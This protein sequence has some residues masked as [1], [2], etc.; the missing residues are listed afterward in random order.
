MRRPCVF[1]PVYACSEGSLAE[2]LRFFATHE[3]PYAGHCQEGRD[4][5]G[6]VAALLECF[7]GA[8]Y[9]EVRK[10][11][12]ST[13]FSYY[14]IEPRDADYDQ[15]ANNNIAATLRKLIGLEDLNNAD[16][17]GAAEDFFREI[18]LSG[19]ELAALRANLAKSCFEGKSKYA[20][21]ENWAYCGVGTDKGADIFIVGPTVVNSDDYNMSL[22]DKNWYR[23]MR[24]LNMQKGIYEDGLRMYAPYYAQLSLKAYVLTEEAREPWL[25][26][27]YSD[28]SEAFRYYL[29]H[30]NQGRPIVLF[31]YSQG[32]DHV[33]RLLEEFFGEEALYDRLIAA[34]AIGW[35]WSFEEAERVPQVVPAAGED[36][37]GCVIS[38]DAEAPE[39]DGTL[40]TPQDERHFAISLDGFEPMRIAPAATSVSRSAA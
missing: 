6:V 30:E 34:Y 31:G 8:D 29:E 7:M 24:A 12:M 37:I 36:D 33:F 16:L 18:G 19:E 35:G 9:D 23:F 13:F 2:G 14:G 22:D 17:A 20:N 21:M 32:A 26:I 11:Y 38:Y 39:V 10:D 3:G 25:E 28:V 15:I 40:V 1:Q 4:R 5:T 27:A